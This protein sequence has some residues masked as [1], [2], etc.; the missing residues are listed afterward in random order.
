ML[1]IYANIFEYVFHLTERECCGLGYK[2]NA[3]CMYT[4]KDIICLDVFYAAI[5]TTTPQHLYCFFGFSFETSLV[6]Y[7][8]S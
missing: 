5:P 2:T 3:S 4:R 1:Q 6:L 7:K 8:S